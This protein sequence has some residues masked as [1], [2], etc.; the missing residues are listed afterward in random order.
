MTGPTGS[1]RL[2]KAIAVIERT[3]GSEAILAAAAGSAS[4]L[5]AFIHRETF[6]IFAPVDRT[7]ST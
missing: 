4:T 5:T 6:R 1:T 7:A 2:E 3:K